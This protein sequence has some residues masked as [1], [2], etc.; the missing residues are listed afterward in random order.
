MREKAAVFVHRTVLFRGETVLEPE[1]GKLLC[2]EKSFFGV[3]G[4]DIWGICGGYSRLET[5][6]YWIPGER[7]HGIGKYFK[8]ILIFP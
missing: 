7:G 1:V 3:I 8:E 2:G 6:F 4:V 5:G